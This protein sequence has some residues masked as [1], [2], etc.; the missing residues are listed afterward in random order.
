MAHLKSRSQMKMVF[1]MVLKLSPHLV[2]CVLALGLE[3][4][5]YTIFSCDPHTTISRKRF[6]LL[7]RFHPSY[8]D[9]L[10]KAVVV[11]SFLPL[12]ESRPFTCK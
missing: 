12:C 8:P 1:I 9:A 2:F 10:P 5:T 4:K 11:D 7:K 3:K 6:V